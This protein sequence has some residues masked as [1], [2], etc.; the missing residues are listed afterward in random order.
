MHSPTTASKVR[1]HLL[2]SNQSSR[3][4]LIK[5]NTDSSPYTLG[6]RSSN[7]FVIGPSSLRMP[8]LTV[9]APPP[10]KVRP[11]S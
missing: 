4:K 6:S 3:N 10:R 1:I 8:V 7:H 2:V 9:F 5:A 11:N